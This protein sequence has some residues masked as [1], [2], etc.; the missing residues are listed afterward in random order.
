MG[1]GR[2]LS[3]ADKQLRKSI[4]L[5]FKELR[6]KSGKNQ[7]DFAADMDSERSVQHRL[8]NGRGATI[9]SINRICKASGITLSQFFDSPLFKGK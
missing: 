9:Y 5:R 4:A 7:T 1:M 3:T 6:E 2:E 8:E